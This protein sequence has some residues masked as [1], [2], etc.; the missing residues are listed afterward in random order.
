MRGVGRSPLL[1]LAAAVGAVGAVVALAGPGEAAFPRAFKVEARAFPV[2]PDPGRNETSFAIRPVSVQAV[3]ANPPASAYARAAMA[4]LSATENQFP[5]PPESYAECDS[6]STNVGRDNERRVGPVHLEAHCRDTPSGAALARGVALKQLGLSAGPFAALGLHGGLVSSRTEA[7][8][9]GNAVGG[10]VEA[11]VTDLRIGALVI[12]EA[13]YFARAS[14]TGQPGGAEASG[15][16]EVVAAEVG[17]IPVVV[18]HDGVRVA[19][20]EVPATV[21]P[22]A[23]EAVRRALSQGGQ[24]QVRVV[25]PE[26][27][28][29]RDGTR[30]EVRGGGLEV[31]LASGPDPRD[32]EFVG[33]TLLGGDLSV[34]VGE[35]VSV[36]RPKLAPASPSPVLGVA[37]VPSLPPP[38]A[39][40]P[41][42]GAEASPTPAPVPVARPAPEAPEPG[43]ELRLLVTRDRRSLP[44][45][46]SAWLVTLAVG[47]AG[48]ALT[49]AS[50]RPALRPLR[51]GVARW[52]DDTAE[53]FLRG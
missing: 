38:P 25:D 40:L 46:S 9:G 43:P 11:V 41:A 10:T 16:I 30:A 13:R 1:A 12:K 28:V 32:R 20:S 31:F 36:P 51:L 53:R 18:G 27:V 14:A 5:P 3:L 52:W 45:R 47:A 24:A 42:A 48:L 2:E 37:R 44:S 8:G 29:A 19:A 17:G 7:A 33:L 39:V 6:V 4:D 34:L 50:S 22:Q 35:P 23:T 15:R 26:T 21:V 49:A